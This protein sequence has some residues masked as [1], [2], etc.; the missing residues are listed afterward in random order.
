MNTTATGQRIISS[1]WQGSDL[2]TS[3][4]TGDDDYAE[5][6]QETIQ[7]EGRYGTHRESYSTE[8][9][10]KTTHA[11]VTDYTD[12][13]TGQKRY[14]A[15]YGDNSG[16]EYIDFPTLPEAI[17]E[18]EQNVRNLQ[19][20]SAGA[21]DSDGEPSQW[22]EVCDLKGV[23]QERRIIESSWSLGDLDAS[24]YTGEGDYRE[25]LTEAIDRAGK[26]PLRES[27]TL[28]E[29]GRYLHRAFVASFTDPCAFETR[30]GYYFFDEGNGRFYLDFA[31][32]DAAVAE[33]ERDV[34]DNTDPAAWYDVTDVEL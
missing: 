19:D 34:R 1:S 24:V 4:Y 22:F 29:G 10:Q 6:L 31:D 14:A 32:L 9:G 5:L 30:Y 17:A 12:P 25:L 8:Y 15:Y 18:Y 13:A 11:Y 26:T 2:D 7:R 16:S 23:E 27:V 28:G 33:Y 3:A 20:C 21:Y